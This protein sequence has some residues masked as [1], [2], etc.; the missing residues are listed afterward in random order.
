MLSNSPKVRAAF[1]CI[2]YEGEKTVLGIYFENSIG[3]MN[4]RNMLNFEKTKV[5]QKNSKCLLSTYY[6]PNLIL[7]IIPL[8]TILISK[9][10]IKIL[11]SRGKVSSP[12]PE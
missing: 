5:Q 3:H 11:G 4:N 1:L 7:I 6:M 9:L 8:G 12:G 10:Q 2:I